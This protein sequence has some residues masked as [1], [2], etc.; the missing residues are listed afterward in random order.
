[1]EFLLV[2]AAL[3]VAV[4]LIRRGLAARKKTPPP[5]Q[6]D[7]EPL[8]PI[9]WD[10]MPARPGSRSVASP[11]AS[12]QTPT[13]PRRH[14]ATMMH[15]GNQTDVTLQEVED[16]FAPVKAEL[17]AL[18][19]SRA[20]IVRAAAKAVETERVKPET[21]AAAESDLAAA[22]TA[23]QLAEATVD[24]FWFVSESANER[25]QGLAE[26]F[27]DVE[28]DI[29]EAIAD[30]RIVDDEMRQAAAAFAAEK[31]DD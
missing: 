28:M 20:R 9:R 6:S 8:Q 10:E 5:A 29:E 15:D 12:R 3:A 1:M 23:A 18:R 7:D 4:W 14:Y 2:I 26:K 30:M 25:W 22:R 19:K 31:G 17:A 24:K 11:P 13:K 16:V 27:A 21:I